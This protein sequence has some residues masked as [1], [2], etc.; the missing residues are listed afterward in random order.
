MAQWSGGFSARPFSLVL[1]V[2]PVQVDQAGNRTLV[3]FALTI[4]KTGAYNSFE[5]QA[6][7]SWSLNIGGHVWGNTF[8]YDFR[9]Y[10]SLVLFSGQVWLSHDAN[11]YYTG[12]ASASASTNVIGSASCGGAFSLARIPKPPSKP[13]APSVSLITS[14]GCRLNWSAPANNGAAITAYQYQIKRTSDGAVVSQVQTGATQADV[15]GLTHATGY[16]AQ[17]VARNSAGWGPWSDPMPFSTAPIPPGLP[18]APT[19]AHITPD[20][21]TVSWAA[22]TDTGGS[23]IT[24]YR[25]QVSRNPQFTD[26]VKDHYTQSGSIR[27][28]EFSGLPSGTPLWVRVFAQNV[29]GWGNPSGY[30][31]FETISPVYYGEVAAYP[32]AYPPAYPEDRWVRVQGYYGEGTWRKVRIMAPDGATWAG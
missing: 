23:A 6:N 30:T 9:A 7:S 28:V 26:L 1:D 29:A 20:S 31:P 5:L 27:A 22:P 10:N 11:G 18:G 14:S 2:N 16:T 3:S 24:N 25:V 12:S 4:V 15:T 13:S 8:A 32:A 21:A 17:V 19:V